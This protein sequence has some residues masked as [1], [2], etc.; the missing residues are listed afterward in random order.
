MSLGCGSDATARSV[1]LTLPSLLPA[2][3]AAR[4]S[5][6]EGCGAE[7]VRDQGQDIRART[8]VV[9]GVCKGRGRLLFLDQARL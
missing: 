2:A 4:E 9:T 7:D 6:G 3:R 8:Q 5:G 1:R